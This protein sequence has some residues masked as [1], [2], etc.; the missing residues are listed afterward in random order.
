[1][2]K[3][4]TTILLTLCM[5]LSLLPVAVYAD[6]APTNLLT[7]DKLTPIA[8]DAGQSCN[9]TFNADG[10]MTA[11]NGDTNDAVFLTDRYIAK[12]EH[13]YI[14]ATAKINNGLAWGIFFTESGKDNP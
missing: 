3:R 8:R 1:M 13:V 14:E 12:G 5:L 7:A 6:A 4:F 11:A 10:S 2:M 9:G